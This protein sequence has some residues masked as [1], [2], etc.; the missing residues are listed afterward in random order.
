MALPFFDPRSEKS[1][2]Q[3]FRAKRFAFFKALLDSTYKGRPVRILDIGGTESY[4]ER[5]QFTEQDNVQITLLNLQAVPVNH[6]NFTSIAGDACDLREFGDKHFDIVFSNSVIEHLFSLENQE[7]MAAEA[8]RVGKNYY[9]QTPNYY[10]P[11]EPHWLRPFFQYLPFSTRVW[12]TQKFDMGHYPKSP[13]REAAER[14][15]KEVQLLTPGEMRTLFPEAKLYR[16]KFFG[17]TK[18]LT[19]YHFVE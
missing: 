16:E 5:M 9:I 3:S 7:K 12:L 17:L 10:F 15:V 6:K 19:M 18:S 2:N 8:R 14:R 1:L 11:F 13:A 4:W